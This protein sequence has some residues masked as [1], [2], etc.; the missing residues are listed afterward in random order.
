M[1]VA[2]RK[3]RE[4][5]RREQDILKAAYTLFMDKGP[6][7]VTNEMIAQASEIGKGTIYKHFKSKSDIFAV[8]LIQHVNLLHC[9]V[10]D[11]L[12]DKLPV[13]ERIKEFL[14][15]HLTFFSEKPGAHKICIQFRALI[16]DDSLDPAIARRYHDMYREKNIMLEKM[17]DE[18]KELGLVIDLPAPDITA[19]VTGMLLGVMNELTNDFVSDREALDLAIVEGAVKSVLK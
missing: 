1:G 10:I 9:Y 2:D 13:L 6:K 19:L 3:A 18:A 11:K 12:N 15:L 5:E 7:M 17:F 8:L 4:F 14:R 16:I